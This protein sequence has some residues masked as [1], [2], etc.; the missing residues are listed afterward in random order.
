M[1]IAEKKKAVMTFLMDALIGKH[2]LS[3]GGKVRVVSEM[4]ET[5]L[6]IEDKLARSLYIKDLAERIGT[7]EK[8][9][10]E[11]VREASLKSGSGAKRNNFLN[12]ELI[13]DD[14]KSGVSKIERRG[15]FYGKWIKLERQ[16]IE[17]MI[18]F[19]AILSEIEE[20]K[21]INLFEDERL[22]S[23]GQL[24]LSHKDRSDLK[25]VD[26]ID[27]VDEKDQKNI[28][29]AMAIAENK[30][31]Y[32]GCLAILTRFESVRGK[33]EQT[34]NKKIQ[35]IVFCRRLNIWQRKPLQKKKKE[36]KYPKRCWKS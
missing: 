19:P 10:L 20:R 5:L 29:A 24:M 28:V 33:N 31:D 32:A 35:Y 8:A 23:I 25:L 34:L 12:N 17:M 30:W 15:S 1:E 6:S 26:I 4:K 9:I 11:K 16:I 3:V 7:D 21:I 2:G 27:L 13:R 14:S 22:K 18:Q 36:K